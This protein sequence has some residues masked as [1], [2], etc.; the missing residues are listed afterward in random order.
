MT[1]LALGFTGCGKKYEISSLKRHPVSGQV[2]LPGG[3]PLTSGMVVLVSADKGL[4][5]SGEVQS[6]GRFHD[7]WRRR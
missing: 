5:F 3:K 4:E 6:D 1:G 2:L 7:H